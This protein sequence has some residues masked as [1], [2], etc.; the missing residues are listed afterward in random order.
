VEALFIG[1]SLLLVP[2]CYLFFPGAAL[3][4]WAGQSWTDASVSLQ[5]LPSHALLALCLLF[6]YFAFA[7]KAS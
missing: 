4:S 3:L 2:F 7:D 5:L 1:A 6:I